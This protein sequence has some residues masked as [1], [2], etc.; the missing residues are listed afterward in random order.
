MKINK[1]QENIR[2]QKFGASYVAIQYCTRLSYASKKW[3]CEKQAVV[4][5]PVIMLQLLQMATKQGIKT[6]VTMVLLEPS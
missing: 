4:V 5:R 3:L 1:D 2:P 6:G